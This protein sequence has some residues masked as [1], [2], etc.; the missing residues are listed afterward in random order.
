MKRS[1]LSATGAK[2]R[3]EAV[4][5]LRATLHELNNYLSV[6]DGNLHLARKW[7][8]PEDKISEVLVEAEAANAKITLLVSQVNRC[9]RRELFNS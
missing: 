7:A 1:E 5:E 2:V 9:I 3:P 4:A 8:A 6:L